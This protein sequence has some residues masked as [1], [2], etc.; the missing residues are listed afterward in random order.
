MPGFSLGAI[1]GLVVQ[2]GKRDAQLQKQ[3]EHAG[4]SAVFIDSQEDLDKGEY[5]SD[6][7]LVTK[8]VKF[9]AEAE[10][11]EA[12][13]PIEMSEDIP[14]WTD[15]YNSLL[16]LLRKEPWIKKQKDEETEQNDDKKD[17]K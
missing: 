14:L 16:P 5:S 17:S 6:W 8:N 1:A 11:I 4:F 7:V 13:K 2:P 12:Q 3:A 15:D 9:L 10:V